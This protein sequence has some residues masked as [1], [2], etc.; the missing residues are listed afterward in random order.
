MK[1]GV[2]SARGGRLSLEEVLPPAQQLDA[3]LV[4]SVRTGFG[5]GVRQSCLPGWSEGPSLFVQPCAS[6]ISNLRILLLSC[7]LDSYESLEMS[8]RKAVI[9]LKR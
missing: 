9:A 4:M 1:Y 3:Q 7:K 6:P 2:P 8:W 5:D